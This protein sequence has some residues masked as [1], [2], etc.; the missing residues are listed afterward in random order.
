MQTISPYSFFIRSA[1]PAGLISTTFRL[2][3]II[4]KVINFAS[5]NISVFK[6]FK[7]T[8]VKLAWR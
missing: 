6:G 8:G 7:L 2:L 3:G 4:A 1:D 5:F